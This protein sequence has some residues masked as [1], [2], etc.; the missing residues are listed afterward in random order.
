[1]S[2][3]DTDA[4]LDGQLELKKRSRRRLV[5]AAALALLAIIVLPMVM[6]HEPRQAVQ[7]IQ[8]RIPSQ[9]GGGIASRILPNKSAATPLP[10]APP[11]S[12]TEAAQEPAGE[13]KPAVVP[14]DEAKPV[15]VEQPIVKATEK[16]V[17]KPIEKPAPKVVEK[18]AEKPVDKAADK[19]AA[20]AEEARA[21]A[22]LAGADTSADQW[23]VLIGAYKD[24]ANV[25]QLTGKLKQIG[26]PAL[27]EKFDSPQGA[28]T[29][30]RAGPFKSREAAVQAQAKMKKIGVDGTVKQS[31]K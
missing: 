21:H 14:K 11:D 18:A 3:Q 30:V 8:V 2:Q 28:R 25:K 27:T 10:P 16:P 24:A 17:E 22:A 4:T 7:D 31:G 29:R 13:A 9:D 23:L 26:I 20:K 12:A 5:G 15:V 19:T 6:D 1:M